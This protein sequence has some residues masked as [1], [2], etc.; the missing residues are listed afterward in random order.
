MPDGLELLRHEGPAREV[1]GNNPL[2]LDEP[3][4]V[5]VVQSGRVD[6]FAVPLRDGRAAGA[7]IHLLRAEAGQVLVGVAPGGP[8]ARSALLATGIPGCRV[9]RQAWAR[10][11]ELAADPS[12]AGQVAALL[13][14]WVEGLTAGVA[15]DRLPKQFIILEPGKDYSITGGGVASPGRGTVW[16]RHGQG[17][18]QFLGKRGLCLDAGDGYFPV[19]GPGWLVARGDTC[20]TAVSTGNVLG[21]PLLGPALE[22]FHRLALE[23]VVLNAEEA[24]RAERSRLLLK[25]EADQRL[26]RSAL[27]RL[28]AV[29]RAE[30]TI[31]PT[32]V[33]ESRVDGL[34]LACQLLGKRPGI[35]FR[36]SPTGGTLSGRSDPVSAIARASRVRVRR[37]LLAGDW[38]GEDNGPLLGF[39]AEDNCPLALLPT[40]PSTYQVVDPLTRAKAP[41]TRATASTLAP[42]A[43]SFYRPFPPHALGPWE[44]F[45][46]GLAGCRKDFLMIGLMGL[47]AGVLGMLTPLAT[48]WIFDRIIPGAQASR[49]LLL[50]LGLTVS[51]LAAALFQFTRGIALVRLETRMDGAVQAGVWDRLLSLP[52]PFFRR[53]AAGDLAVRAAGIGVIRVLLTDAA[54]SSLLAGAFSLVSFVLLLYYSVPLT[55]LAVLL[56]GLI[57]AV[58]YLAGRAELA[59]LRGAYEVRGK[60]S[61]VVL[62]LL[63]G[64]SRLRVAGA[65]N[66]ALSLW[67]RLFAR[68]RRLAFRARSVANYLT[69][70]NAATPVL[71]T[72]ALFAAFSLMSGQ[73]L[74]LGD[75]LAFNAAFLQILVAAVT[76]SSAAGSLIEIVPLY[77]RARPI[78]E[79]LPEVGPAMADPGDLAGDVEINHV[80]FRYQPDGPLILDDVSAHVRAGEFVAFVGPSGAG[81]STLIRLLLGFETPAAGSVY[82]DRADLAGL[83]AQAV[84]RQIGV[85]L[86]NG[87]LTSGD[88][89]RNIVGSAPLTLEDAWQAARL[90]GLEEDIRQM[91]M[92]MHTVIGD[93]QSTLSGGQQ[94]RIMIARAIVSKPRIVLFDEATSA[95]D[96]ETQAVVSRSLEHL[97]ATRIVVAHRLSTIRNADRIYVLEA[98]RVVQQGRY[99]E[100]AGQPGLFADLIQRQLA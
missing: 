42:F 60:V 87:K 81:K 90:T 85:V 67:A 21:N 50:V 69:A 74:S 14:G 97:K 77:E 82:Y 32:A 71:T 64:L 57:L 52:V 84:R 19:A 88:I 35:D 62:E 4:T 18:T 65:E 46:F 43:Y 5:W 28:A 27:V 34:F 23:C 12:L 17:S 22:R 36:P 94:Q 89:F 7:L 3:E 30:E 29:P 49:L 93:G 61:G 72:L 31:D 16:V 63:T 9:V 96:N 2:S 66:R 53:Y 59:Y 86:Q 11:R 95:L 73:D 37:V 40:S 6:V 70:F 80:S 55:F 78:L 33:G 45:R 79:A 98:G 83:D 56:V 76:L 25:A 39:R 48:G 38:W 91:P 13:E 100:L 20:L 41:V 58:T 75:F 15:R 44:L 54:L 10:L 8:A 26:L 92:G 24:A 99:D 47:A 1:T 68:Q 51:A